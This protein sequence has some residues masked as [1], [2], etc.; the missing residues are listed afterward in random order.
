MTSSRI[1]LL[2]AIVIAALVAPVLAAQGSTAPTTFQADAMW[3]NFDYQ[4][5]EEVLFYE[6]FTADRV[7]NFPQRLEFENG[8]MQ[9]VD[10]NG[11]RW[12]AM[13]APE[14]TFAVPLPA[15]LPE[16]FTIE[17]DFVEGA[18]RQ[19]V[20]YGLGITTEKPRTTGSWEHYLKTSY[21]SVAHRLGT[22]IRT[23]D[24]LG[25]SS[26]GSDERLFSGPVRIRI[27]VDG[28]YAKLYVEENRIGNLPRALLERGDRLYFI[29]AATEEEPLLITDLTIA[30]G[31]SDLYD[32]LANRESVIAP[33]HPLRDLER[34]AAARV[35]R[36]ARRGRRRPRP[37]ARLGAGGRRPHR[38]D[39]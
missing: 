30:A 36:G 11:R 29:G 33:R 5:G 13:E 24:S 20:R 37:R 21:L 18:G 23:K 31:G 9:V 39:R 19:R 10:W 34:P 6:D 22:G 25:P 17:F 8:A 27:Q 2:A 12:V 3:S 16:R 35:D 38:L 4:A 32:A 7:G 1:H 14:S 15:P 28:E 26:T